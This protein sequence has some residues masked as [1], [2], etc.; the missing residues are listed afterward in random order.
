VLALRLAQW[1]AASDAVP[2]LKTSA[3]A[4]GS[5]VLRHKNRMTPIRSLLAISGRGPRCES[6]VDEQASVLQDRLQSS[7]LQVSL[8][9]IGQTKPLAEP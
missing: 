6:L 5:G 3:A 8:I 1:A 7:L 4:S 9:P 2:L